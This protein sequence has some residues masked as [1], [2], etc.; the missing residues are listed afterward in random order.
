LAALVLLFGIVWWRE[1]A[2]PTPAPSP[3][4]T[5]ETAPAAE[6]PADPAPAPPPEAAGTAA[7][8]PVRPAAKGPG[9]LAIDLEHPLESGVLRVWVDSEMVVEE[10]LSGR[11]SK[12]ALVFKLRKGSYSDVLEVSPGRHQVRVQIQWEDNT[13]TEQVVGSFWSGVTRRLQVR[14]GRLRKN[15]T[16]EWS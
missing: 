15:L 10:K 5:V 12:N 6:P 14:L 9:R 13:R 8:E 1:A 11:V 3:P 2:Q 7:P 4:L 16:L